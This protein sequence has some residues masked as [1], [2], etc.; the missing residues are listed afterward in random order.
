MRQFMLLLFLLARPALAQ[1][2]SAPPAQPTPPATVD[3]VVPAGPP[4]SPA[5]AG[6][7]S[8]AEPAAEQAPAQASAP[9]PAPPP[10]EAP[11]PR[12]GIRFGAGIPD[13]ATADLVFRPQR[14][15]RLQAGPAWD[16]VGWGVQGGVALTPFRWAISPVFEVRYGHFFS[17]NLNKT[18]K[19]IPVELQPLASDV[20]FDYV[21]G[22]VAF[23]FGSPRGFTFSLGFG[24][25]YF[26]T[27]IRGT[28]TTV[29]NPG[30]PDEAT[31][32][33]TDPSLSA[34]IPSVRLGVLYYF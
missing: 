34:V 20:A 25:S 13:G 17:A 22:Q 33:V 31:V 16:Y 26:W 11:L 21:N 10:A 32:T 2:P 9:V 1:D 7:A 14:W 23:E 19:D 28:G 4:A 27:D 6:P 15:L 5:V 3:A 12:F 24:L 18:I 30:T 8:A 29:Q